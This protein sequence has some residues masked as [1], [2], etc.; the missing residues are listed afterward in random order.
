M[1]DSRGRDGSSYTPKQSVCREKERTL[2]TRG[3]DWLEFLTL[4]AQ[5][6]QR[7]GTKLNHP[8][9]AKKDLNLTS[10]RLH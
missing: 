8:L 7:V 9:Q 2:R 6:E 5:L 10:S 4:W 1:F 3:N